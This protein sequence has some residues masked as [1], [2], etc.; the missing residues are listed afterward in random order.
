MKDSN[1]LI[2]I[3]LL[4]T[5]IVIY[6][7][8]ILVNS[9]GSSVSFFHDN[10]EFGIWTFISFIM[11]SAFILFV[12]IAIILLITK[13][14]KD[15]NKRA[16]ILVFQTLICAIVYFGLNYMF[17]NADKWNER[18]I[19]ES[20]TLETDTSG[21]E[22]HD[23]YI[24]D[25]SQYDQTF[26]D[27][28]VEYNEPIKLI[29]NY[30]L[31]GNDTTYFPNDLSLNKVTPFKATKD[32]NK[33]VLT[34]TR[35]NLTN[36]TYN[37]QLTDK[38]NKILDTKSGKAILGSMFFLASENDEDSQTGDGYGSCEYWDKVN[39]C[40]FAIRVGIGK[41]YN[42]KLRAMLNYGCNDKSKQT[43]NLDEC[44]T[45]RTE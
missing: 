25:K 11:I 42:G 32:N 4:K 37:F 8:Y 35:T 22:L 23:I 15:K 21:K 6:F 39:D 20:Q 28:L 12:D 43:L 31:T 2:Q 41:D 34:V 17:E 26:I 38:D 36:L 24:K 19:N 40:W 45:L 1:S 30:I 29:D 14:F 44:P 13:S 3:T 33:F 10:A 9:L 16:Y 18:V 27:G 5:I 7:L